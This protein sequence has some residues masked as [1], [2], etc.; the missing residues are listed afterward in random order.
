MFKIKGFTIIE[1]V[2]VMIIIG[3]LAV[4]TTTNKDLM[5]IDVNQSKIIESWL[6]AARSNAI[7]GVNNGCGGFNVNSSNAYNI[8]SGG[9]GEPIINSSLYS[10]QHSNDISLLTSTGTT[11][12]LFELSFTSSG[13]PHGSCNKGCKILVKNTQ[14][15]ISK[16]GGIHAE[17]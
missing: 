16:E 6:Y 2:V 10:I 3:V 11:L 17:C 15:C 12:N 4:S 13:Q 5:T 9:C 7:F 14:I 8:A 1:L